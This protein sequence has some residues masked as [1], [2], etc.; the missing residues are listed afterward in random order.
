M[1]AVV[2]RIPVFLLL[3]DFG[4]LFSCVHNVIYKHQSNSEPLS[5]L[6]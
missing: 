6:F 2:E 1:M 3:V 5:V 4:G